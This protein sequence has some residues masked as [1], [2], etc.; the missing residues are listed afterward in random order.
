[1]SAEYKRGSRYFYIS[2]ATLTCITLSR[3]FLPKSGVLGIWT[4]KPKQAGQY[5][6]VELVVVRTAREE[7]LVVAKFQ[8]M[9]DRIAKKHRRLSS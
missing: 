8:R 9:R 6:R 3:S 2:K 5:H 4:K 1:M 7:R